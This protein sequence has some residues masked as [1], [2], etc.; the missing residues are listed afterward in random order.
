MA[1]VL[2]LRQGG[3]SQ[4]GEM[5]V[6]LQRR[7]ANPVK[8]RPVEWGVVG[9]SLDPAEK[10]HSR[11]ADQ[12]G[13]WYARRRAAL[14]E[15]VEECGGAL[16]G[17]PPVTVRL[18]SLPGLYK[19]CSAM[20]AINRQCR[21]PPT[22]ALMA[23]S[24]HLTAAIAHAAQPTW[25]FAYLLSPARDGAYCDDSWRPTPE[26]ASAHEVDHTR[27][28][29]HRTG[30]GAPYVCVDGYMW[31]SLD[32]LLA[33]GGKIDGSSKH[34]VK[35]V[36]HVFDPQGQQ[37]ALVEVRAP[38]SARVLPVKHWPAV[39]QLTAVVRIQLG[40][41]LLGSGPAST[42]ASANLCGS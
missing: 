42:T 15:A 2:L 7:S 16:A 1:H 3:P 22:L 5:Q 28:Q 13:A 34:M 27:E 41:I 23:D 35:W 19:G 4:D 11:G 37:R 30:G 9:G 21:L 20:P 17:P 38:G 10:Q 8:R 33:S 14:R 26:A 36:R 6:L 29:Y 40:G 18:P 24:P 32:R 39:W 12:A 31:Y 25:F